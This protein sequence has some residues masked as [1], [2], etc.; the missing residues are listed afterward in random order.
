MYGMVHKGLAAMVVEQHGSQAWAQILDSAGHPDPTIVSSASYPDELTYALVGATAE[1]LRRDPAELL[2]AF[3]RYWVAEFAAEHYRTLLDASG[4]TIPEFL[5]N[6]NNLHVRVGL[7]FP[8]YRPPR[9]EV[10]DATA[11]SITV[12]Y[13]SERVGLVPFVTGLLAGIGDR[14]GEA[15]RVEHT[16]ARGDGRDHDTFVMSW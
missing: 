3:G 8:G 10:T 14:F 4:S 11:D 15:V 13:Y 12:H 9:F 16:G 7:L 2:E 1:V 6:L 5:A